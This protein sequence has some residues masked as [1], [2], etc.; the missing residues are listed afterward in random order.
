MP[1]DT[2][3]FVHSTSPPATDVRVFDS[4]TRHFLGAE[5]TFRV[6]GS[7]H[8]ISAPAYD[9]H[10]LSSCEPVPGEDVATIRLDA[11]SASE[12]PAADDAGQTGSES[13]TADE[14]DTGESTRRLTYETGALQ[15]ET[16]VERRPLAAFP[17]D[18]SFDLAY[19]FDDDAVTTIDLGSDGY[20]TYHTYPEVDLALYT[21]TVFESVPRATDVADVTD[22][23]SSVDVPS[24]RSSTD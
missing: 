4:L 5:F 24:S 18:A 1:R 16:L 15:C 3:Q 23:R 17:S 6:V 12:S 14:A 22:R 2:L 7:S 13:L 20:E 19:W 9:F 8:Y 10:E 11:V 21:R